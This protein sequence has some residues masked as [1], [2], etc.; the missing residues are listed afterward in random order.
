MLSRLGLWLLGVVTIFVGTA[1]ASTIEGRVSVR[2]VADSSNAIVYIDKIAGKR[3]APPATAAVLD[4]I[5][6]KFIP[7][8]LPILVGTRVAFPNSDAIRH[9]VFSPTANSKFNLGTYP[10]GSTMYRVFDKPGAVTLLCNVHAEMSAYVV[11]LETPYFAVTD[12]TGGF[13]LR[14]V[15]PGK[16]VLKTWHAKA[17]PATME[18]EV[19]E[20]GI[21]NITFELRK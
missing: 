19:S 11:V 18:I 13:T 9:N 1:H 21:R 8:V 5:N 4:Q 2:G 17:K 7:H 16:Y 15:P 14:D 12:K 6:L 3:F 10:R 20:S